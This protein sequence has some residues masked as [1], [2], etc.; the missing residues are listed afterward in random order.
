MAR[1]IPRCGKKRS[2]KI[3]IARTIIR[4]GLSIVDAEKRRRLD[5]SRGAA[6]SNL[7]SAAMFE[8]NGGHV[9]EDSLI[10]GPSNS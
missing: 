8:Q 7:K 6:A 9:A 1:C 3:Q 5:D 10:A 2:G 4:V